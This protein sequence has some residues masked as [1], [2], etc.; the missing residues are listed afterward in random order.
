MSANGL[1]LAEEFERLLADGPIEADGSW[2]GEY[3]LEDDFVGFSGHFPDY[4]LMPAMM[5]V[6]MAAHFISLVDGAWPDVSSLP[7]AKF[8]EQ[9]R[10]GERLRV[11]AKLLPPKNGEN[12][13]DVAVLKID[14]ETRQAVEGRPPVATFKLSVKAA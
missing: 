12:I 7:V 8:T 4:P 2:Q 3:L 14:P 10:P 9:A 5:Q 13:W 1:Q 6:L 11:T